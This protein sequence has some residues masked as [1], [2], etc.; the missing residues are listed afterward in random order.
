MDMNQLPPLD[1][2]QFGPNVPRRHDPKIAK[3][4]NKYLEMSGW[5]IVGEVPMP[6]PERKDAA[7]P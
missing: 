7:K 2:S 6:I 1:P 4:A 5:Q 3:L